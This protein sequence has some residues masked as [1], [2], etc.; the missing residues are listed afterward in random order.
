MDIKI[1][2]VAA[3]AGVSPATVSRVLNQSS[4][5]STKTKEKVLSAI[6]QLGYHPNA[7]AKNLRSQKSMTICVIVPDINAA[8]FSEVIKGIENMAYANKYKVIICDAQNQ[9]DRELDY[10]NLL[11]N[12]TVDGAILIASLLSDAEIAQFSDRGYFI[13]VVGRYIEH[14]KIPCIYTDNVKFSREVIHHLVGQNHREIVFLSGYAEAIDSYERLEGYLKALREHQ[15]PF[16]PELI[17][18]G[19][20][21]EEGGY[22]AMKRLFEKKLSFTAVFAANDEMALGVYRACAEYGIRIPDQLAVVGV[23]N[24]RICKYITPTM[25]TVN[26]P[27]YTMGAI[28]VEKLIDQM[29]DNQHP[30]KRTFKVDSE[31]IIRNSSQS[32]V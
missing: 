12:R 25:S 11:V 26:Q 14:A 18:N 8:Y 6:E 28:I 4:I 22:D 20:F 17:E 19:N 23:D 9:K 24:N 5:V 3:I 27:K 13:A 29:N 7:A 15:I 30:D 21:N 2:D 10:L 16:R 31:L 32:R 1:I